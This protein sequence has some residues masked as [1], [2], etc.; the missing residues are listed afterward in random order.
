M[1]QLL[2]VIELWT[3]MLDSSDLVDAIYI[4]FSKAF[5][6]VLHQRLLN[7][8]KAYGI[9]GDTYDWIKTVL[10]GVPI[11]SSSTVVCHRGWKCSVASHRA[12][13]WDQYCLY[14]SYTISLTWFEAQYISLLTTLKYI[15][16][17]SPNKTV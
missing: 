7:K 1:T 3:E 8:L 17:S 2:V 9:V 13:S 16:V 10:L 12:M 6:T 15:D 5:D 14:C 11:E 4:D